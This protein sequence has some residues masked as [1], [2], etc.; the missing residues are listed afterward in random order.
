MVGQVHKADCKI[1]GKE[2]CRQ[3]ENDAG[4]KGT[5]AGLQKNHTD[6]RKEHDTE[7]EQI[8]IPFTDFTEQDSGTDS[9]K[10]KQQAGKT[11]KTQFSR[12]MQQRH[13]TVEGGKDTGHQCNDTGKEKSGTQRVYSQDTGFKRRI[14][15]DSM[16]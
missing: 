8:L 15:P 10:C 6:G 5:S 13:F 16:F 1:N 4:N 2:S 7:H 3:I 9:A 14:R 12:C 11:P